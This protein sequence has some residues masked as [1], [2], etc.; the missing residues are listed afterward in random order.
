M[1]NGLPG[2]LQGRSLLTQQVSF[3]RL[4]FTHANKDQ[5]MKIG[6]LPHGAVI[7]SVKA[8]IKTAFSEAKLAIGVS[9]TGKE[10][11]EKDIKTQGTQDFTATGQKEFVPYDEEITLYA[12]MDKSVASG[13]GVVVVQFVTNC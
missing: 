4:N 9:P 12:K 8:F 11:G 6:T 10:F 13:E 2:T 7:T 5:A 1:T 3:F